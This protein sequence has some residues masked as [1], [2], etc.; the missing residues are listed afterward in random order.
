MFY[1]QEKKAS[2]K[3]KQSLS[4][5]T[6]M[7]AAE[8]LMQESKRVALW[9]SIE[10]CSGFKKAQF[11]NLCTSL[12]NTF[13]H[14]VQR[15]PE[16]ANS[17]YSSLGGLLDHALNR[18]EAAVNLFRNVVLQPG[19]D[20]SDMQQLWLY[21]LLSAGILQGIGKLQLDY[22]VR[23]FDANGEK[24]ASWQPVLEPL[25]A[26]GVC[27]DYTFNKPGSEDLR[28]CLNVFVARA[29][30]PEAGLKWLASDPQVLAVWLALLHE[31]WQAAGPLGALLVRAD[32]IAIWRSLEERLQLST[33]R[34]AVKRGGIM[35]VPP[36]IK[37]EKDLET[38]LLFIKWLRDALQD[39][40]IFI[41]QAPLLS[42][43]G[44]LIMSVELYQLFARGHPEYPTWLDIQKG[45]AALGANGLRVIGQAVLP[46]N[47]KS[48]VKHGDGL[49]LADYAV[50]L[51]DVVA[52]H[53]TKANNNISVLAVQLVQQLAVP[54][55]VAKLSVDGQWQQ[56][57]PQ[58][59]KSALKM[60]GFSRG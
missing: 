53:D 48:A 25:T 56:Q 60:D 37:G 50:A 10:H 9:Q 20:I 30:M 12:L 43:P 18:T 41:N 58:D 54:A 38:G 16:T 13:M 19:S 22:T 35:D 28:R 40:K 15:L 47:V 1:Q 42:V 17:Y 55:A 59:I 57:A 39:G 6:A 45:V 52:Y 26:V 44:G 29:V 32:A 51:P 7:L 11:E 8:E 31:D 34:R 49:V 5:Y 33:G 3:P 27:Y 46:V 2:I 23:R 24:L 21:A 36:D 14:Y 4:A